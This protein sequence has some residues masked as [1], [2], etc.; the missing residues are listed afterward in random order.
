[1][2]GR[3]G[4]RGAGWWAWLA[5]AWAWA[6]GP[7]CSPPGPVAERAEL[8]MTTAEIGPATGFELVVQEPVV[9]FAE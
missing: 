5:L 6:V 9:S 7:G 8:R 1:M 4:R 3:A 2:N